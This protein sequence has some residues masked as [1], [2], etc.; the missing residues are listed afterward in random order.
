MAKTK[1]L[2]KRDCW[3]FKEC[4]FGIKIIGLLVF[5]KGIGQLIRKERICAA[6]L[7]KVSGKCIYPSA[8]T[9]TMMGAG[10][11]S[12][13]IIPNTPPGQPKKRLSKKHFKVEVSALEKICMDELEHPGNT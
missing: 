8:R 2:P 11:A 4:W 6:M 10:S 9:P 3:K 5:H 1:E 12:K 13:T 7:I